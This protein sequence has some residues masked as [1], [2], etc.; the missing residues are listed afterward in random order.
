MKS[1]IFLGSSVTDGDNGYSM[2]EYVA[3]QTGYYV[4][5]LAVRG[6]TLADIS[7]QSYVKRLIYAVSKIEKCD[8]FVCQLSTNDASQDL[9]L[10]KM[11]DSFEPESFD[12]DTIIG[13]IEFIVSTARQ[14]WN[15]PILFYTGTQMESEKYAGMVTS[16]IALRN[17]WNF[18][19]I[20]L[21]NSSK[22]KNVTKEEY[23][24]Y[25]KDPVHPSKEGYQKW[26]GPEFIK[27]IKETIS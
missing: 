26:W 7:E 18:G 13:A 27:A 15:C 10:G 14:K 19:I 21:W 1:I 8:C 24:I 22:M 17:K 25:M 3:E 12:V 20:D 16:L 6:T 4:T 11:T 23:G 2:C 9:P 5:K